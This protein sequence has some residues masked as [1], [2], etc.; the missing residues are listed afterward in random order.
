MN[1]LKV[2]AQFAAYTWYSEQNP[3]QPTKDASD[4]ARRNWDAFLPS[5][6]EG[7]GRFLLQLV[8]P[9]AEHV[10]QTTPGRSQVPKKSRR[11]QLQLA[12]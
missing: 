6:H 1:P 9:Q 4:F 7:V 11:R 8:V 5:A 3:H 10:H 2:S 12:C